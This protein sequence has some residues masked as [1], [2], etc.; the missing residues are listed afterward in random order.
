MAS[1]NARAAFTASSAR[2]RS[3]MST[4]VTT[5]PSILLSRVRSGRMRRRYHLATRS[6]T[7]V[8]IVE[9]LSSTDRASSSRAGSSILRAKAPIG[10]PMS[11]LIRS[12]RSQARRGEPADAQVRVE[13]D[14][15]D[16]GARQQVI[17]GI[18]ALFQFADL[19]LQLVVDRV[20]L[21]VQR[22]QFLL[23]GL[24]LLVGGL[25]LLV[26]GS[27]FFVGR[28]SAPR[29]RFPSV[30]RCS[31]IPRVSTPAP[32]PAPSGRGR[33]PRRT[34]RATCPSRSR[35]AGRS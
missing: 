18:G 3:V 22:L 32:L 31:A 20:K 13:K 9:S 16:L 33:R 2:F 5:T 34:S 25:Q 12:S 14:G 6:Q 30:R 4:K 11:P 21:F 24:E 7:T 17:E 1:E 29:W 35:T 19:M 10:R 27:N 28:L 23:R 26:H 15:R 8:S